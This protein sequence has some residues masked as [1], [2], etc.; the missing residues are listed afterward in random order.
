MEGEIRFSTKTQNQVSMQDYWKEWS[1][2]SYKKLT[3]SKQEKAVQLE[4]QG[5]RADL[6]RDQNLG[7]SLEA[8]MSTVQILIKTENWF[9]E[10][11]Y[12]IAKVSLVGSI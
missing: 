10:P 8:M 7:I 11:F 3:G 6:R 1:L 5:C 9:F 12:F 4:H 2:T